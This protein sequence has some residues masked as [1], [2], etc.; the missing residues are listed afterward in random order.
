MKHGAAHRLLPFP[1]L[2]FLLSPM[3]P[4]VTASDFTL[5]IK[6]TGIS[7]NGGRKKD[8]H[9]SLA[10]SPQR[11]EPLWRS[12][13]VIMQLLF[14]WFKWKP[15]P[16]GR[17]PRFPR[18]RRVSRISALITHPGKK[19][20]AKWGALLSIEQHNKLLFNMCIDPTFLCQKNHFHNSEWLIQSLCLQQ[21]YDMIT[22]WRSTSNR[23]LLLPNVHMHMDVGTVLSKALQNQPNKQQLG[24][25]RLTGRLCSLLTM[26]LLS[27]MRPTWNLGIFSHICYS[28]CGTHERLRAR[29]RPPVPYQCQKWATFACYLGG[30]TPTFTKFSI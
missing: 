13:R 6:I 8:G 2:F 3:Q 5:A 7:T 14:V 21:L 15:Q 19:A 26:P 16:P 9:Q 27:H 4:A 30:E 1:F 25:Y 23:S 12:V 11:S 18:D 17:G 24:Y 20:R 22:Q 29:W 10:L 28:T